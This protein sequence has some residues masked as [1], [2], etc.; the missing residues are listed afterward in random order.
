MV[1]IVKRMRLSFLLVTMF[2]LALAGC[3]GNNAK[4]GASSP[5]ASPSASQS[6]SAS[7]DASAPASPEAGKGIEIDPNKKVKLRYYTSSGYDQVEFEAAYPDWQQKYPNIE[8][9]LLLVSGDDYATKI[10]MAMVAG[11]QMDIIETGTSALDRA[12]PDNLYLPLDDLIARDG[13]DVQTEFGDYM[14]QLQVDGK[15]YGIPRAVAPDGIYYNKKHFEEAG[16]P[17]PSSGDWT[18]EEFFAAAKQLA[19]FDSSGKNTR[20][21][22]MFSSFG[23]DNLARTATNLALYGGWEML[24]EDGTFN[25]DWTT[26]NK[27]VELLYNAVYVDK[28]MASIPELAARNIHY[29]NDYYKGTHSLL[30]GGRNGAI[31]TDLAVEYGQETK[32]DDE[33]GIHTLAPMPRWDANSPKKQAIE[34][35]SAD[36]IARTS[37]NPEEAY[38]FVKWHS[39]L[40]IQLASKVAHRMPASRLLDKAV[41]L[42]N[43][44]WYNNKDG[45]LT[46][47]KQRDD[48]YSRM[49]DPEIVPIF[50]KN[51]LQYSYSG[52]MMLELEKHLSLLFANETTLEQALENAKTAAFKIYEAESAK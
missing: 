26:F 18:W 27:A 6:S 3:S 33:A 25:G 46:Q 8:V 28:S 41:L 37:K 45:V 29:L 50:K 16:I 52:K 12:A 42:E 17:D 23:T 24:Q 31:F 14:N 36:S 1:R 40:S 20:F 35:I 48:L 2:A 22:V 34:E 39:T 51:S 44:R 49:M 32:E 9:E 10:K 7:P 4:P 43:W 11:E 5:S 47:G 13:W 21:G 38:L 30:I 15:T 19:Q